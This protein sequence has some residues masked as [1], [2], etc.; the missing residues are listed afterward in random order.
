[1]IKISITENDIK[2]NV[3]QYLLARHIVFTR[4]NPT[5]I[6][7]GK[8]H[9]VPHYEHGVSDIITL[10]KGRYIELELKAAKGVQSAFQ[11]LREQNV[12]ANGGEY[13]LVR[14]LDDLYAIYN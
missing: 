12:K 5:C 13:Y 9:P 2:K 6:S 7:G 4:H 3:I 1:M 11:H 14:S 10:Y 8:L